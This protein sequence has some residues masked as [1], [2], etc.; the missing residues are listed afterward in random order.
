MQ[1][2]HNVNELL[3]STSRN[4]AAMRACVKAAYK[5]N[6]KQHRIGCVLIKGGSIISRGWNSSHIHSEHAMLNRAW[7][8]TDLAGGLVAIVRI[9]KDGTLGN[10]K[11]CKLCVDRLIQ[12]GIKRV[13]FSNSRG[14]LEEMKLA[15]P[16]S[17]F[18]YLE[19]HYLK[20][21]YEAK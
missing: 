16:R 12:A 15:A 3:N 2:T 18:L 11:P 13:L 20:P 14:E 17:S 1:V 9:R 5:S 6:H 4:M 10:S 21:Q 19:Y 7:R 8:Q